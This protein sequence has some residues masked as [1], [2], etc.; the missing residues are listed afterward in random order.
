M[1]TT[2]DFLSLIK[3]KNATVFTGVSQTNIQIS[4]TELQNMHIAMLPEFMLDLYKNTGG[5]TLGS[6]CIFGPQE[7]ERGIKYP[8]PSIIKIN[9]DL[10]AQKKLSGKTVF[11]RNDLFL[12][13][14]DAFGV[15]FMLDNI[16]LSVLRKYDDPYR[17]MLDCLIIGKI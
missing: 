8:L 5:L 14:F 6:A 3:S 15:C 10:N 2:S 11:G 16:T 7:I 12:F 1:T 4:N 13:A 17:A 9:K